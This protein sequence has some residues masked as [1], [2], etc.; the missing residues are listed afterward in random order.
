MLFFFACA[1]DDTLLPVQLS[2]TDYY[3]LEVGHFAVYSVE[4][5]RYS[6][7]DGADTSYYQLREYVA[8]AYPGVGG[9]IIYSLERYTRKTSED[10]W[11]LDSVWTA[12]RDE[13]RVVVVEN[14]VPYL[15]LVFPFQEDLRWDGNA[16]NSRPPLTYTLTMTDSALR[17]EMSPVPDSLLAASRTVVQR[18]LETLVNDS[19]LLETYAPDVGL[20]YKK[21]RILRY[22]ADESCF[23][24]RKIVS[25]RA[26]RQTLLQHGQE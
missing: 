8:D 25:G 19:V 17:K 13:Q 9:E 22:C 4:D 23:G 18:Q 20:L 24:Q 26:Y 15:K 2:G 14:N 10:G 1:S 5:V 11:Q 12:R 21:S 6:L 16:L 7:R 3:P